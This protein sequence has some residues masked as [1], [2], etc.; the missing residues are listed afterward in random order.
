MAKAPVLSRYGVQRNCDPDAKSYFRWQI[1]GS[2]GER[3]MVPRA[4]FICPLPVMR[5]TQWRSTG[6]GHSEMC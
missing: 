5:G 1:V 4:H 3:L 2:I 6:F